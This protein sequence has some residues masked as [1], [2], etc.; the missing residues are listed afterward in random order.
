MVKQIL[1]DGPIDPSLSRYCKEG[2]ADPIADASTWADDIRI[3][4]PETATLRNSA[5]CR[6]V[7]SRRPL[8]TN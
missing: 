1:S 6:K 8:P 7:A 2:P 4:R 5:P 3:L